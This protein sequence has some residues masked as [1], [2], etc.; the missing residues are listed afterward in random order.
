M[1]LQSYD[2][3]EPQFF[4]IHHLQFLKQCRNYYETDT[5]IFVHANYHPD[6]PLEKTGL[7][8]LMWT[9]L[10]WPIPRPHVS[11]KTV[12]VGHTAQTLGAVAD[13]GH[14]ICID[15]YCF[16]GGNLTAYDAAAKTA[17]QVDAQ[18]NLVRDWN[19]V[20]HRTWLQKFTD[21]LIMPRAK[22]YTKRNT[23]AEKPNVSESVAVD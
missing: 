1:T 23:V 10:G 7:E 20:P 16:G 8:C 5:H 18:G 4:P 17:L 2:F 15:T 13:F 12:I 11:G 22:A 21:W 6:L 19:G 3:P 9:H 14:L